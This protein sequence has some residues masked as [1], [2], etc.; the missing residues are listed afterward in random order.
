[1]SRSDVS[2]F[3]PRGM[4]R[5]KIIRPPTNNHSAANPV[6]VIPNEDVMRRF[7]RGPAWVIIQQRTAAQNAQTPSF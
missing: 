6:V 3:V 1:M 4:I 7:Y 2:R 5:R